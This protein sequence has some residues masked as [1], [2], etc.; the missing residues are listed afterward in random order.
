MKH[1]TTEH[2]LRT[3]YLAGKW[4]DLKQEADEAISGW[5]HQSPT[6]WYYKGVA[7]YMLDMMTECELSLVYSANLDNKSRARVLLYMIS[8]QKKSENFFLTLEQL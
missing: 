5:Y 6:A 8:G 7:E 3:I 2:K 4:Q 1:E